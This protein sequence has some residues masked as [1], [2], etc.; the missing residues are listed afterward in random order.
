MNT[1]ILKYQ[2]FQNTQYICTHTHTH[3]Q[4]HHYHTLEPQR[5]PHGLKVDPDAPA[6]P[7]P[8]RPPSPEPLPAY[9]EIGSVL[10]V[11]KYDQGRES[12]NGEIVN[13]QYE[14]SQNQPPPGETQV[15]S[16]AVL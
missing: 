3:T 12:T 14:S 15:S 2:P 11:V 4:N 10:Q 1:F 16:E 5:V 9:Q 7:P 8:Y 13:D 6:L